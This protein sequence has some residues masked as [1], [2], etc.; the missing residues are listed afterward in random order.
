MFWLNTDN[1]LWADVP[2]DSYAAL[3]EDDNIILVYPKHELV[4]VVRWIN[5]SAVNEFLSKIA[6]SLE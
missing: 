1:K 3:D 5:R 2:A 6:A 4:A